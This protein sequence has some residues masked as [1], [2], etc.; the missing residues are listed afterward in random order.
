MPDPDRLLA[1]VKI[2]AELTGNRERYR[3][4]SRCDN[5]F[6]CEGRFLYDCFV[7]NEKANAIWYIG[8]QPVFKKLFVQT[9]PGATGKTQIIVPGAMNGTK[10]YYQLKATAAN[11]DTLTYGSAITTG[12]FTEMT[13]TPNLVNDATASTNTVV[14]VVDVDAANK[15][16]AYGDAI[17]NKG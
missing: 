1:R 5:K 9:A 14:R 8:A 15:P 13:S 2:Y 12:N 10:R 6:V 11:F 4:K 3:I 16:L 7:L 17:V